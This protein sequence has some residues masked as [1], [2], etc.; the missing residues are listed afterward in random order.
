MGYF[1]LKETS[2]KEKLKSVS[3]LVRLAT[4]LLVITILSYTI[5]LTVLSTIGPLRTIQGG[6]AEFLGSLLIIYPGF[7]LIL[8]IWYLLEKHGVILGMMVNK[9]ENPSAISALLYFFLVKAFKAYQQRWIDTN[10]DKSLLICGT[11]ALGALLWLM[12]F[13]IH[14][15][16]LL[17]T[18][19]I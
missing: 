14:L 12:A 1:S 9:E 15:L 19:L 3:M 5:H 13:C 7:H 17:P 8:G 16:A 18:K 2:L 6:L 10:E 4:A 11:A